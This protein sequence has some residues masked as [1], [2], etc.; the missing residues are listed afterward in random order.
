VTRRVFLPSAT[1]LCVVNAQAGPATESCAVDLLTGRWRVHWL[2]E[3][4]LA[5]GSLM[6]ILL[7]AGARQQDVPRDFVC[8][9]NSNCWL[10]SG[11]GRVEP[12]NALSLSCNAFFR[13]LAERTAATSFNA[14]L[15]R[16][17]LPTMAKDVSDDAKFGLTRDYRVSPKA[18]LQALVQA[19]TDRSLPNAALL[20]SGLRQAAQFGTAKRLGEL[21]SDQSLLAK[22]G[23]G[24]C[25]HSR[26][27]NQDGV[28]FAMT[29][30]DRPTCAVLVRAHGVSGSK[31][32]AMA[33]PVLRRVLRRV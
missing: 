2:S 10:P 28:C 7:L 18:F 27:T 9:P 3:T 5:P 14:T 11:H 23:T 6:K 17:Q 15:E 4:P 32:A 21:L 26:P 16:Y 31:A 33:A 22:T 13:A 24:A 20:Q 19:T 8:S 30:A 29:P 25:L 1:L 12:V